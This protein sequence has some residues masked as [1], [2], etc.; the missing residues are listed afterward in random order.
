MCIVHIIVPV[1]QPSP[2]NLCLRH[3]TVLHKPS[4]YQNIGHDLRQRATVESVEVKVVFFMDSCGILGRIS[5]LACMNMKESMN[6]TQ[7][8]AEGQSIQQA[9]SN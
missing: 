4:T 6:V 9:Q 2:I 7:A 3:S 1:A 8:A 5:P